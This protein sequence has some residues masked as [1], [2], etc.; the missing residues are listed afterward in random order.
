MLK[1]RTRFDIYADILRALKTRP[2]GE[3]ITKLSY[4]AG[5][6]INRMRPMLVTLLKCGLL[7]T[8]MIGQPL[9]ADSAT[10]RFYCITHR[11]IEF[12]ETYQRMKEFTDYIDTLATEEP[13]ENRS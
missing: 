5:L 10:R 6:P 3:L 2:E 9:Y 13:M 4:A 1:N 12:L 7:T 11:G 8:R